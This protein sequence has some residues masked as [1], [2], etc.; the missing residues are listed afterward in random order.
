[1]LK[2]LIHIQYFQNS[3]KILLLIHIDILIYFIIIAS[4]N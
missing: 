1:M 3:E 4:M 2:L